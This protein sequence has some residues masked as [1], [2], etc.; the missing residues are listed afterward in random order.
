V[1]S[2]AGAGVDDRGAAKSATRVT[3]LV[4]PD[5]RREA[6]GL[7]VIGPDGEA[8]AKIVVAEVDGTGRR[9]LNIKLEGAAEV[10]WFGND[11]LAY[12]TEVPLRPRRAYPEPDA[13]PSRPLYT[14]VDL[15][16]R[17]TET[18]R[19][20]EACDP[21]YHVLSPDGRSVA[22]CGAL[23]TGEPKKDDY[24]LFV[25]DVASGKVRKVLKE[26]VKTL[27]AWSPD[28]RKLAIGAAGGYVKDYPLT[29]IDVETG[30]S[31]AVGCHGVGVGWSPDG[32]ALAFTTEVVRGGRWG[33]GIPFDGRIG[34]W[35]L[36]K[37]ALT[38]VSPAAVNISDQAAGRLE[39]A[40]GHHPVW[41][42]DGRRLA[43]W[44]SHSIRGARANQETDETWV[45]NRDGT[46]ARKVL[47][48]Q[49]EVAWLPDGK[50]LLW[51]QY[52]RVGRVDVDEP[53]ALG[54]TPARPIGEFSVTGTIVDET[55]RP[56]PGVEVTVARGMATLFP[57]EPVETDEQGHYMA[58][59]GPGVS[60][61][62]GVSLQPAV[63]H[64]SKPGYYEKDLCR[65]GDLG[66]AFK[67]PEGRRADRFV[68]IVYP[69]HPYR[70]DFTMLPAARVQGQLVDPEKKPLAGISVRL[71]GESYPATS[72]LASTK[73]DEQGR[74]R[75]ESV[76]LL[77][78]R[79]SIGSGRAVIRSDP[80]P[81]REAGERQVI[82]IYRALDAALDWKP[83]PDAR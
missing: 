35:D 1:I 45:V 49:A 44:Q 25:V 56:L 79:F 61:T 26:A 78:Y 57:T 66:M 67:R 11:H 74:F 73:T 80:M 42:P 58:H 50:T 13:Q 54:Q 6:H 31:Q 16:G 37:K 82:M 64:A 3:R 60:A 12:S 30:E 47:N 63:V 41:S 77:P 10:Y 32:Q 20:P 40:G 52:G 22:Y 4:S 81:F 62:D 19:L 8:T 43:Y 51:L 72:A 28:S 71:E 33:G 29:I 39:I 75:I 7:H 14:I 76:P 70:L 36:S 9:A 46:G 2:L 34:V 17:T 53:I 24:G 27:P 23:R 55:G 83:A 38:H 48:H 15:D 5:G 21:I 69:G 68:A 65:A 59:F 18:I